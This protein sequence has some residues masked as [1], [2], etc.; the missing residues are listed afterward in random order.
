M[1]LLESH[2]PP[3]ALPLLKSAEQSPQRAAQL[4]RQLMTYARRARAGS[5]TLE[6]ISALVARA[7]DLCRSTFDKRISFDVRVASS[8]HARVDAAQIEQAI[9]NIPINARDALTSKPIDDPRVTVTV[10]EVRSG[11]P[12][13]EGR[14][15][16]FA[17]I[18]VADNG[19]GMD[20]ATAARI[21]EPFFTTK[22]SGKGTGLGLATTQTTVLEHGGFLVCDSVESLGTTFSLYLPSE[23]PTADEA[24][25][26]SAAPVA[27][28]GTETVLVI[29]DE[30]P[31]RNV[32]SMMLQSAGFTTRA[33]A[34]GK[35]ALALLAERSVAS[36]VALALVDVSMP[37][38][39][40]RE[41]RE[42]L[43]AIAPQMRVVYFTGYAFEAPDEG[44]AVLEKPATVE[45]VVRTIRTVLDQ[46]GSTQQRKPVE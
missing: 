41:L 21:Y 20:A 3:D 19:V 29:D 10:E 2:V 9:V 22:D 45:R 38:M 5:R 42:R 24:R 35:E 40:C 30:A 15:G 18:R 28:R 44:D 43:R 13:L 1:E 25:P 7:V 23:A 17:R 36:E 33:A 11:A 6:P 31:I 16:D 34:S 12:E 14:A 26:A 37:G 46:R 4:V 32:V 39:S 27:A 8:V